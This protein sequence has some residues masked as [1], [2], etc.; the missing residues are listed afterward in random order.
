M[1][2]KKD[3]PR[4]E[5]KPTPVT[6]TTDI[7]VDLDSALSLLDTKVALPL[8]DMLAGLRRKDRSAVPPVHVSA[9][10][11]TACEHALLAVN[12]SLAPLYIAV[13]KDISV[14]LKQQAIDLVSACFKQKEGGTAPNE[15]V[16]E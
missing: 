9:A 5:P 12:R 4:P 16:E 1:A 10:G 15:P 3:E 2:K 14:S 7:A 13:G 8:S 11:F 6:T